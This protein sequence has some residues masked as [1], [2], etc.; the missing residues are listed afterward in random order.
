[1]QHLPRRIRDLSIDSKEY[2]IQNIH[3]FLNSEQPSALLKSTQ[4]VSDVAAVGVDSRGGE[5]R[6]TI[7][8]RDQYGYPDNRPSVI[9][10]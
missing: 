5:C 7:V 4:V 1:M 2:R 3:S 6:W 8:P 10:G 9:R